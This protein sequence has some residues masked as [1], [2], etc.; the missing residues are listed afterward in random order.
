MTPEEIINVRNIE[1]SAQSNI[2]N[3]WQRTSDFVYP[4][5]QITSKFEDGTDRTK[6][7]FDLTPLLDSEDMVSNLKHVLFPAGQVFFA[8]KVGNSTKLPDNIQRY[9]SMLTEVAHDRI[10]N[11]NFIT[12]LDEV[13]RSLIHFGPASIFSEWTP[14][15]GLNYRNTVIGTYQLIENSKKLVDGIIITIEYTPKQ[16]KEEFGDKA[17][18]DILK[19]LEDP[20]KSNTKFEFIYIIK[21]REIINPNLS[22][23]V[24]TNMEWEEQ[25]V[26]VK[27]KL[28]VLESGY[29][30]FPYHTARWKRPANEKNG[31][32][33]STELLPQIKVLNRMNRDF[34]EVGNKWA[35]P[36]RETLSS[37]DGRYRTFPGAN[38]VVRELPTSRAVDQGLNGNFNI[39]EKSLDRQ[40]GI[41]DRAYFRNAF[42]PIDD[43]TGDRRTQL[44]IR[45]RVRGTWPKIGNPV[46][47]IWYE[48]IAP[49]VERSI[50]LLIRNGVVEQPP[51]E[52]EGVGFGLEFVSP[53][54][55]EL[56]SQQSKAFQE[57]AFIVGEM[58]SVFPGAI[59]NVD[60]D[61]AIQRLGRT[62]GVNTEDM[63]SE[64]Q[65]TE[66]REARALKERE[67]LEL[68]AAQVAG[69]AYGQTT[70]APEKGS[71]AELVLGAS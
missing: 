59:D 5:V 1:L 60:S 32:G 58:E 41:I 36:A 22:L 26:N 21:P 14:R 38:N 65:R 71:P 24:N 25:V 39:T 2:R 68:Q 64:E 6:E 61:D 70:A 52:L 33:I 55:L 7:I 18:P 19:A 42:N 62:L 50:L 34:N 10:F 51:A 17:G 56:R 29:P 35:N 4:Y 49:L 47:R 8:I 57:W 31:R 44:E 37:F 63:S 46:A 9:I 69:Q 23:R 28:I 15:T 20:K 45:E 16:A 67:A 27:E 66:K 11:S 30:Q 53:F 12:E 13:L 40:T 3:L 48:Q 43:L 54:A